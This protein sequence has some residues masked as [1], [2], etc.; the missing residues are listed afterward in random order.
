MSTNYNKTPADIVTRLAQANALIK[1]ISSHGRRFFYS[2]ARDRTA[3]MIITPRGAIAIIDD[4]S[5]KVIRIDDDRWS[6]WSH[7]GTLRD[8]VRKIAHFIKT[9]DP[10]DVYWIGPT[11]ESDGS[12]IW[13]YEAG[14]MARCRAAAVATGAVAAAEKSNKNEV[15][16]EN[17]Q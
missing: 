4:Y 5:G 15:T 13:G 8:L 6:G 11:R 3:E 2:V 14:E 9:G 1:V 10:L 16:T 7:G 12:N 17:C